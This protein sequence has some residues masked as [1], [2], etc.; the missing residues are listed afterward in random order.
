MP[1]ILPTSANETI[2]EKIGDYNTVFYR[3]FA[4]S[5]QSAETLRNALRHTDQKRWF[6]VY[7]HDRSAALFFTICGRKQDDIFEYI[8][9]IF[10]VYGWTGTVQISGVFLSK[11][12]RFCPHVLLQSTQNWSSSEGLFMRTRESFYSSHPRLQQFCKIWKS[13][14]RFSFFH[15][16]F[17]TKV[18]S[19]YSKWL[20]DNTRSDAAES[21]FFAWITLAAP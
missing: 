1:H 6:A 19:A 16:Y 3:V 11:Q 15:I 21:S 9:S 13:Y 5:A 18:S 20:T 7:K 17:K 2:G 10:C 8:I 14:D 4:L 12:Y